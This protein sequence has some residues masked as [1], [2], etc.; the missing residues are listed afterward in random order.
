MTIEEFS[1]EDLSRATGF[2]PRAIRFYIQRQLVP[3]P[4]GVGRG[5]HYD[6]EHLERLK[7]IHELQSAG[8]SL[9]G[10]TKIFSGAGAETPP[11]PPAKAHARSRPVMTAKLWT[12]VSV[13]DGVELHFDASRHPDVSKLLAIRD[14]VQRM[15]ENEVEHE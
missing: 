2:S 1:L 4:R 7:K 14:V 15:L 5:N 9:D 12:R 6:R 3:A 8:H 10:I 11:P 13:A